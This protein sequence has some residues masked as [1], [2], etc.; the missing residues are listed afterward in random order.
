MLFVIF[1]FIRDTIRK[2]PQKSKKS[3]NPAMREKL[4]VGLLSRFEFL[5]SAAMPTIARPGDYILEDGF[6][7]RPLTRTS[8]WRCGP[9]ARPVDPMAAITCPRFTVCPER[10]Y[11]REA[12]A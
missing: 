7:G 10:T 9:V 12:W 4:G 1:V 8:Q 5:G 2:T 11:S 3:P 6:T